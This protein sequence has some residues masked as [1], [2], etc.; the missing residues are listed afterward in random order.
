MC[1]CASVASS[2]GLPDVKVGLQVFLEAEMEGRQSAAG[3]VAG[4][5]AALQATRLVLQAGIGVVNNMLAYSEHA[6][7]GPEYHEA[8]GRSE[9]LSHLQVGN[10]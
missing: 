8:T 6:G 10:M 7:E 3:S 4:G 2:Y 5:G 1:S 9:M